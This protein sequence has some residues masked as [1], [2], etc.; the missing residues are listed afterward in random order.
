MAFCGY[1]GLKGHHVYNWWI[2]E[3]CHRILSGFYGCIGLKGQNYNIASDS[4]T[5]KEY[6]WVICK[7]IIEHSRA[8][9][10]S[11]WFKGHHYNTGIHFFTLRDSL[12]VL[13]KYQ[14][15]VI[16]IL[17]VYRRL[18]VTIV[19]LIEVL[20]HLGTK[21]VFCYRHN[22]ALYAIL[23]VYRTSRTSCICLMD[24]L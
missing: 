21:H 14:R 20:L 24:F 9:N 18:K 5:L 11:T 2:L 15:I 19:T 13:L 17:C 10:V 8:F 12:G 16:D 22:I 7:C 6:L 4:I 1:V 3:D 23:W